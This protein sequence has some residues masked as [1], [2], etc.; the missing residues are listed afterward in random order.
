MPIVCTEAGKWNADVLGMNSKICIEVE[1]KHS[2]SDLR[3]DFRNKAHKHFL[4]KQATP[5]DG[6]GWSASVPN[7]FYFL[8]P[9][10]LK[11]KA[12][13]I[14]TEKAPY[15]GLLIREMPAWNRYAA[16]KDNMRVVKVPQ[17]LH[18]EPP[19]HGLVR[20]AA[21]RMGSEIAS[22]RLLI[23]TWDLSQDKREELL[24][25]FHA[26]IDGIEGSLDVDNIEEDLERRGRELAWVMTRQKWE[27]FSTFDRMIWCG[28]AQELLN[29]RRGPLEEMPLEKVT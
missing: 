25:N 5:N 16:G 23:D 11:D 22:L 3:A 26:R 1:I 9:A 10:E 20:S 18:K 7:F 2:I 15:A 13:E 8:T 12:L 24:S 6:S 17:K 29:L 14:I 27:M 19:T 4:Y 28:R 21:M